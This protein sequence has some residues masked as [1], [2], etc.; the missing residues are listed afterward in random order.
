MKNLKLL[1]IA[2]LLVVVALVLQHGS[3]PAVAP[4]PYIGKSLIAAA[5]MD[6]VPEIVIKSSQGRI[7]LKK[8]DGIWRL[9][10]L[11][12]MRV[13]RN[14]VEELFQKL[15]ETKVV[16]IVTGN[17]QRHK[18]LG[19]ASIS[20]DAG[21]SGEDNALIVL[22]DIAGAQLR[23][24]YLGKGR[25]ARSVDGSQGFGN[26]GQYFR[27]GDDDG[28]YLLSQFL[29][30][31]KNQKNWLSKELLKLSSD[32]IGK[33]TWEYPENDTFSLERATAT[34][35][36]VLKD[37]DEGKQTKQQVAEQIAGIFAALQF[38]DFVATDS[39]ALH[40]ALAEKVSLHIE[41]SDAFNVKLNISSGPVDIPGAGKMHLVLLNAEYA[42]SDTSLKNL[43][44]EI[45]ANAA[46]MAF[47]LG[48]HRVKPL[49]V[50]AADLSEDKP[51]PAPE[52]ASTTA[53]VAGQ[54]AASHILVA[55]QGAERSSATRS[56]QEAENLAAEL[57]AKI[58]EGSDFGK[59]AEESSD[60][61]SGKSAAGSLGDFGRGMMAKEFEDAAFALNVGEISEVVK[62]P[63][64]YHIIRRDK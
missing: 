63:F 11:H 43:A 53:S 16:E 1:I 7:D 22:K 20:E 4:D 30:L 35:A 3:Q 51:A 52:T 15:T 24:I 23:Q 17:Q 8:V 18:D 13:D 60:C 45:E 6:G 10:E 39:P 59:L 26:D 29:W 36:L 57:L 55:Y 25:Q 40:P 54:I 34:S 33:I 61:P 42:G 41:C 5:D 27:F 32:K 19:V 46:K 28:V 31:E 2:G 47:A 58:K 37:L 44:D 56:Q 48:E 12:N 21:I 49:L 64:G 38:D 62:S 9:P 14:R 50:K